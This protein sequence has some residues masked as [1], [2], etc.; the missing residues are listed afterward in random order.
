VFAESQQPFPF[1]AFRSLTG[2]YGYREVFELFAVELRE[3]GGDFFFLR[4]CQRQEA[5]GLRLRF[6]G[7]GDNRGRY[8]PDNR[9][10]ISFTA[11]FLHGPAN[12]TWK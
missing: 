1:D 2:P 10:T 6:V 5:A 12:L 11:I 7:A 8:G 4:C 9:N 3:A